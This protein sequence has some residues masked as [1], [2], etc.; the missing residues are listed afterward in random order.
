VPL[1]IKK[2]LLLRWVLSMVRYSSKM[3]IYEDWISILTSMD[4]NAAMNGL[5]GFPDSRV[6]VMSEILKRNTKFFYQLVHYAGS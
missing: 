3:L 4:Y 2:Y 5:K 1:E 6:F